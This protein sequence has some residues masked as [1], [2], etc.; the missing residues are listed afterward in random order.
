MTRGSWKDY[1]S[2]AELSVAWAFTDA[3]QWRGPPNNH[4]QGYV[5]NLDY[6]HRNHLNNDLGKFE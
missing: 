2:A 3:D 5:G 6:H 4:L 1:T